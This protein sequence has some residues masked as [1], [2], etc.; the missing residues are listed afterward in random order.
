MA[1]E[2]E[3]TVSRKVTSWRPWSREIG[4]CSVDR[5]VTAS[6]AKRHCGVRIGAEILQQCREEAPMRS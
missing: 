2:M 5:K 1:Q 6:S 3:I 4:D